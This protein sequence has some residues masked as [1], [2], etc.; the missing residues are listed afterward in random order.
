MQFLSVGLQPSFQDLGRFGYQALGVNPDGAMDT[1][2]L[3]L[4]NVLLQN[5]PNE[6]ALEMY[7]PA[8]KLLFEEEATI[9]LG[10]ADFGAVLDGLELPLY[11]TVDVGIGSHLKF[12]K[13]I[14]GE[15]AYLAVKGGFR[16]KEW[17]GSVSFNQAVK[18]PL[19]I[20]EK[21][22]SIALKNPAKTEKHT[23]HKSSPSGR[24]QGGVFIR[25]IAGNEFG[26]LT[27]NSREQLTTSAFTIT[28][29][30]NRMGYRLQSDPLELAT[31]VN[32]L[33][34]AVTFGTVQLLPNGQL[35][36]L[37]AAHQT[38]GGYP[39]I[40][41]VIAVDLPI[42][43]QC[44]AG[45]CVHFEQVSI[46]EAERLFFEREQKLRKLEIAVRLR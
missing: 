21:G 26:E 45:Q 13:K 31:K 3:R 43:G 41:N 23:W 20:I 1:H 18:L 17:L 29:E 8:P 14:N 6:G 16:L 11:K 15:R 42:L 4:L 30:A 44:G 22:L 5:Q 7:F 34:A 35:I 10:G 40:G 28:K 33:S 38:T 46:A 19:P 12:T 36:V 32:L 24:G 25:F 2:A 9:C 27:N 37:M 39:R